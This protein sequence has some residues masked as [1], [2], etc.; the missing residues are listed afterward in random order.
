MWSSVCFGAG[1]A[2]YF[3]LKDEPAT[4]PLAAA[5]FVLLYGTQA[6][7]CRLGWHEAHPSASRAAALRHAMLALLSRDETSDFAHP[8]AWAPFVLLGDG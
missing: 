2:A 4:W 3:V 7:G 8:S 5:A 6:L 1:C